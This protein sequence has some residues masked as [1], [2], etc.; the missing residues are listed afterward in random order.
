MHGFILLV[1]DALFM[2]L[3][4]IYP[5]FDGDVARS[6]VDRWA[7]AAAI[8]FLIENDEGDSKKRISFFLYFF[9]V[10]LIFLF[11]FLDPK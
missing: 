7:F 11:R 5:F 1:F 10:L 6:R 8:F 4:I 9:F 3:F 2:H